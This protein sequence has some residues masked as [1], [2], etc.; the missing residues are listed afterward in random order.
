[1]TAPVGTAY[2]TA[3]RL[4]QSTELNDR[5]GVASDQATAPEIL[6]YLVDDEAFEVR[7]EIAGNPATPRQADLR[8]ATDRSEEVRSSLA[9]KISTLLPTLSADENSK[10]RDLTL[11]ILRKLAQDEAARVRR[12]LS[13]ALATLPDAPHDVINQLARD[14]ELRVAEP[15]LRQS[16]I[17]TDADL[18]SIINSGPIRGALGAIATRANLAATVSAALART[19]DSDAIAALL[20]NASAQIREDTLDT[21]LGRAPQQPLWH[22]PLVNRP[23]LPLAAIKRLAQFVSTSL[24]EVLK[25]QAE[26]T[27]ETAEEIAVLV[28]RRVESG[29]EEI[30]RPADRARRLHSEDKLDEA[31]ITA[32]LEEGERAFVTTAL[33]L[34]SGADSSAVSRILSAGSAKGVT[35]LAWKA[36][37]SMRLALQLQTRLAGITPQQALYPKDGTAYPLPEADLRW[38]LEFF[39]ISV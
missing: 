32:A 16:P 8:L 26:V 27:P 1:M 2:E 12:I 29:E 22:A 31:T 21:L 39:G 10:V 38:Q 3:K 28:R 35:A 23:H 37:L 34:K 5:R 36:G 13:E 6:Y 25:T 4:S 20:A 33:A 11:E 17:L 9:T 7:S 24:L 30:E 18:L 15:V 14:V 19:D